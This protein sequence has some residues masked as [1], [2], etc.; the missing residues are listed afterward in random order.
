MRYLLALLFAYSLFAGTY[1]D[2]YTLKE[3]NNTSKT[4]LDRF[5]YQDF[6]EI[7]RFDMLHFTHN[8]LSEGSQST[9]DK[10]VETIKEY[11]Q[12]DEDFV[13][14]IIGHTNRATDDKNERNNDSDTYAD[15]IIAWFEYSLDKN[16]TEHLSRDYAKDIQNSLFKDEIKEELLVVEYRAGKDMAYDDTNT[17]GRDLSNRVMVTMYVIP[18]SD[19]DS[20]KDGVFDNDDKCP[21]TPRGSIVDAFGCPI[22]RDKDGVIDYKDNCPNTPLGVRVD[23]NGCPFDSDGDGVLDY[24]DLCADT[25]AGITIDTKGCAI[26]Q[27][28]L[29]TFKVRSYKILPESYEKVVKFANFLKA[30]PGYNAQIIG[31]TDSVGKAEVNMTLSQNRAKS[32]LDALVAEGI[33]SARLTSKGRGELD[34]I[35]TNRTKEGRSA[36]RRIEVKLAYKQQ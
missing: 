33:D 9:Y 34:P 19:I 28:L 3:N 26:S 20:D 12:K 10:I 35:M 5:M 17:K 13:V 1:D 29:L 4:K 6:K 11:N 25:P 23:N 7:I 22:D 2:T 21:G 8:K 18:P 32:A 27:D 15:T 31:H 36:N 24:K 30:N 14:K 16:T